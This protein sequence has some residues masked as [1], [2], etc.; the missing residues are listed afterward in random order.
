MTAQLIANSLVAASEIIVVGIAFGLIYRTARFIFF[1]QALMIAAGAYFTLFLYSQFSLPLLPSMGLSILL[2]GGVGA[3]LELSVH[4]P[5]RNNGSSGTIMLL[6]SLG[7]LIVG[8]NLISVGFGDDLR[9]LAGLNI[10]PGILFL[11]ARLSP[12]RIW[13]I[14]VS[15]ITVAFVFLLLNSTKTG[16]QMRS[17]GNSPFLAEVCGVNSDVIILITFVIS[18]GLAGLAGVLL[19]LDTGMTPTMGINP[20]IL[21]IIAVIIAGAGAG[22]TIGIVFAGLLI[23]TVQQLSVW[24]LGSEWNETTTFLI[25]LAVLL[26]KPTGLLDQAGWRSLFKRVG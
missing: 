11:G 1:A 8:Q 6:A 4:R 15:L 20:L 16:K 22:D 18:S 23:G 2:C 14:G 7:V 12:I 19:A 25:L 5:L 21:G 24:F 26:V 9:T 10:K 13:I 17:V 3:I